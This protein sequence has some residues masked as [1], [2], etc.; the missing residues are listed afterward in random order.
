[1]SKAQIATLSNLPDEH[2]AGFMVLPSLVAAM[3]NRSD[4]FFGLLR[5]LQ[6]RRTRSCKCSAQ[7]TLR[8]NIFQPPKVL[9]SMTTKRFAVM[10]HRAGD[11]LWTAAEQNT[12]A[13]GR[14]FAIVE[15]DHHGDDSEALALSPN[16][17]DD[18]RVP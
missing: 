14:L 18:R 13:C 12:R 10:S 4:M 17:D 2:E 6:R 15:T 9:S 5:Y 3:R 8:A 1:V 7:I 16:D 11:A